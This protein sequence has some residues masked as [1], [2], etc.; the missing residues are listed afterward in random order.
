MEEILLTLNQPFVL[1]LLSTGAVL[2]ILVDYFF[3]V[4]WVAYLGYGLFAIF[5]GATVPVPPALSLVVMLAVGALML[6]LHMFVFSKYLTNAPMHERPLV[7]NSQESD[8][9]VPSGS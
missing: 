7:H 3:P 6:L 2:A 1:W 4:D 8:T 5:I 9:T